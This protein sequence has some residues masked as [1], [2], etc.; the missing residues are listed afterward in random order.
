MTSLVKRLLSF[1]FI[2]ISYSFPR[3][4]PVVR[5]FIVAIEIQTKVTFMLDVSDGQVAEIALTGVWKSNN[6]PVEDYTA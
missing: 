4:L 5:Y 3:S 6:D 2:I 1:Q